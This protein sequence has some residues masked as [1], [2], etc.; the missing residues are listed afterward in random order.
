MRTYGWLVLR[1]VAA[2]VFGVLAVLWPRVTALALAVLFG[3]YALVHGV[4][5]LIAYLRREATG[6]QRTAYL[7]A[8]VLGIAAGLLTLF[9]PGITALALALTIGAW[10][11]LTGIFDISAVV[12][13]RGGA[14]LA[15]VG[16]LS[17]VAGVLILVRPDIGAIAIAQVIGVYAIVAGILMLT[18]AV[19]LRRFA[20]A[21]ARMA[22]GRT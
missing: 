13:Q 10:A 17:L 14:L 8:G 11:V 2:I 16:I 18:A 12:R 22:P 7:L 5:M 1:G 4:S 20:P 6:R 19:R 3:A 15:L 21:A 9:W